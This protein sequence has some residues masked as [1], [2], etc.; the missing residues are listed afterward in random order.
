MSSAANQGAGNTPDI[1]RSNVETYLIIAMFWGFHLL[2]L[3]AIFTGVTKGALLCC[4]ILYFVRMFGI[5]GGYHRYFS[6][7]SYSMGRVMQFLMAWL[8]ETSMQRGVLWWASHHRDHHAYSDQKGDPHSPI[9]NTFWH[10]HVLWLWSEAADHPGARVRDLERFPE[11][12]WLDRN[13]LVPPLTL[14]ASVFFFFAWYG[15]SWTAGLSGLLI[16]FLLSTV[17]TWHGTFLVNSVAHLWGARPYETKDRSRNNV[18]IALV[19]LGEGWHNNHHHYMNSVRQGFRWWQ[20]DITYY[21]LR[22]MS[23]FGLVR[24][25]KLP[26]SEV[27][28]G[29]TKAAIAAREALEASEA[30]VEAAE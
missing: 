24:D 1:V 25:L 11:L 10:A 14:A 23:W 28:F 29:Q 8:A 16:G 7:K 21:M 17:L 6:H 22:V 5:T 26:P 19:T 15:G 27:V 9:L 13:W 18:L 4:A 12:V 3:G 20:I 2:P 30:A